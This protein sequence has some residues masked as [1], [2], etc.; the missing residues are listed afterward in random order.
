VRSLFS[1]F[2]FLCEKKKKRKKRALVL[3]DSSFSFERGIRDVVVPGGVCG[4]L[5]RQQNRVVET[6]IDVPF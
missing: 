1:S 2:S 6:R 3:V 4:G 5:C